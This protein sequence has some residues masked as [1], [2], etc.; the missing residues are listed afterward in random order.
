M[1][2]LTC[3]RIA[4]CPLLF[5]AKGT[6]GFAAWEYDH[7]SVDTTSSGLSDV[8]SLQ[9]SDGGSPVPL[10]D[11]PRLESLQSFTSALSPYIGAAWTPGD[12]RPQGARGRCCEVPY[13]FR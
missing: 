6:G 1:T 2:W 9:S 10:D 7:F 5:N 12:Q 13:C 3:F 4:D 11:P 8:I